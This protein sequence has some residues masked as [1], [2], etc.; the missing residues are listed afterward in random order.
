MSQAEF[1]LLQYGLAWAYGPVLAWFAALFVAAAFFASLWS[2]INA[3]V[4][5]ATKKD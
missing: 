5:Y 3:L 4:R 1:E 2:H